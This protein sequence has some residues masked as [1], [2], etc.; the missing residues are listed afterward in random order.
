MPMFQLV[1]GV[2]GVLGAG[3]NIKDTLQARIRA[4]LETQQ[5]RVGTAKVRT[6]DKN[7]REGIGME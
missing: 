7:P 1:A 2:A 5:L 4:H 6:M 3:V